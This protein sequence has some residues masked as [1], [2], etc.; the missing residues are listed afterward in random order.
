MADRRIAL[1]YEDLVALFRGQALTSPDLYII[2]SDID[3]AHI[4]KA[5]NEAKNK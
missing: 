3:F 4:Q 1:D 2:L 5:L